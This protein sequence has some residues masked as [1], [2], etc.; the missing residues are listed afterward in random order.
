MDR[1]CV[2]VIIT[3]YN[4]GPMLNTC[5][6]S[7]YNQD[8]QWMQIICVDDGSDIKPEHIIDF[9]YSTDR[10]NI[11]N[12][13]HGERAIAR[14]A[15]IDYLMA[16]EVDYLLFLDSD[17]VLSD[18]FISS[19]IQ[20]A[21]DKKADGIIFPEI[22]Y[23]NA[24]NYWS[25]VKVFERNLYQVHYDHWDPSSIE[26]ARMWH[27]DSFL[28]F[29]D[30][31]KAFEEIQPTIRAYKVGK[32]IMKIQEATIKHD[33]KKVSFSGLMKKKQGYFTSMGEHEAVSIKS[34]I[35]KYYFFRK[36][37]Y[38]PKNLLQYLKHPLLFVGVVWMYIVLT[39]MGIKRIIIK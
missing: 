31:L 33:E 8:Y 6:K 25:K 3:T 35:S 36:Q 13:P 32:C 20:F 9:E 14:Q 2:G 26:A 19:S 16:L 34:M 39:F 17:M 27:V 38:V 15:G 37:L 21:Q 28:G 23:S 24:S 4:D 12:L 10:L 22:A 18:G 29:E 30:G 5:L 7:V 1:A 11:L